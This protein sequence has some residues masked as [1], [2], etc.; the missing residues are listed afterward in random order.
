MLYTLGSFLLPLLFVFGVY[1]LLTWFNVFRINKRVFWK[2]GKT[3]PA[4]I[5]P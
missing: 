4:T 1:H 2:R 3:P 5:T